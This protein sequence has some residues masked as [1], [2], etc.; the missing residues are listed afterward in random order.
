[1]RLFN[2]VTGG[3]LSVLFLLALDPAVSMA[4]QPGHRQMGP[5]SAPCHAGPAMQGGMMGG[6]MQGTMTHMGM[7]PAGVDGQSMMMSMPRAASM[8]RFQAG[9]VLAY[10]DTLALEPEQVS[11]LEQL[12]TASAAFHRDFMAT[13]MEN[14][15]RLEE[16]FEAERPDT[17]AVRSAA[18]EVFQAHAAMA[19]RMI[20]DAAAVRGMLTAHQREKLLT[21][22]TCPGMNDGMGAADEQPAQRGHGHQPRPTR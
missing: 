16:A 12:K 5:D 11:A 10:G 21:L 8:F 13:A 19:T 20:A 22:P 7:M 18:S 6:V 4:Q 17:A 15:R 2:Q 14:A 3:A 9:R 1:M